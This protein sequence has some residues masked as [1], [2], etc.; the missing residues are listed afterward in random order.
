[1]IREIFLNNEIFQKPK[2]NSLA[3]WFPPPTSSSSP[4][5]DV[6]VVFNGPQQQRLFS[7]AS[8][9]SQQ[10]SLIT[11]ILSC[12][13]ANGVQFGWAL[14]LSLLTPYIQIIDYGLEACR[15]HPHFRGIFCVRF[16]FDITPHERHCEPGYCYVQSRALPCFI[17]CG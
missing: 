14:Q 8:Y 3:K 5:L 10:C 1:M 2:S 17:T 15:D 9:L 11:L 6:V 7:L 16:S 13:V 12:T 4:H